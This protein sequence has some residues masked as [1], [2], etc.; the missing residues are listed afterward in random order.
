M[1]TKRNPKIEQFRNLDFFYE[2][3]WSKQS[4]TTQ[5]NAQKK[6]LNQQKELRVRMSEIELRGDEN[7]SKK[8]NNRKNLF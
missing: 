7:K 5:N 1:T 6:C 8:E 2:T 3:K 4:V